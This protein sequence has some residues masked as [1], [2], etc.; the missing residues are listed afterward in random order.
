MS[1]GDLWRE[2]RRF[3]ISTLRDLGMGKSWLQERVLEE[4]QFIIDILKQQKGQPYDPE[5]VITTGVANIICAAIFG[6]R[7]EH[8]DQDFLH[9]VHFLKESLKKF[10]QSNLMVLFPK[11][12]YLPWFRSEFKRMKYD[13]DAFFTF[14]VRLIEDTQR[15]SL[16]HE[17]GTRDY[18]SAFT[19]EGK[20]QAEA[21][22]PD[23]TFHSKPKNTVGY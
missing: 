1:D 9:I 6:K 15:A 23:N 7:F 20:R 8:D 16:V 14:M 17:D 12:R 11:L 4:V 3:A 13:D 22:K 10:G 19:K 18:I 21:G 2:H 5:D